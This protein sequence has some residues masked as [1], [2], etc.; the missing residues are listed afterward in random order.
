MTLLAAERIGKRFGGIIALGGVDFELRAGEIHALC[1]ENGAG[2]STLIKILSGIHTEYDGVLRLEGRE[3]R[4]RKVQ[5]SE[6]AGIAVIHQELALVEEMTVA[7]NV[8]L[9]AEPRRGR[10]IDWD[11]MVA[12]TRKVLAQFGLEIDVDAKVGT[13]GVAQRQLVEIAKALRKRSRILILDEPTAALA[14]HEAQ[15]LL[16]ILRDLRA[17]GI[18]CIYVSHRLDE[19]LSIADRLTVLRDG[20]SIITVDRATKAE[21]IRYMVGREI[22]ELY[23]QRSVKRGPAMLRVE[24][25]DVD[26]PTGLRGISFDAHAGEVLGIGGLMGAGRTELL[27]HICGAWGVRKRGRVLVGDALL[28][29][30][31]P[32][33]A[34]AAGVVLVS[35]DRKRYGL[36]LD[37]DIAFNLSL[38][39]IERFTSQGLV[40]EPL[41]YRRCDELRTALRIKARDLEVAARTLSGG[42]QQKV[43]LGKALLVEPKVVLLDEP[44]RGIDVGAKAEVY[45]L[46]GQ[47]T[48][49]GKTVVLVSSELPEL[50]GL[51]D[52]ILMLHEG[53]VAGVFDRKD[54]T[55]EKLLAAAM[56]Q[57]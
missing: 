38:S 25:L 22:T 41:L 36:V 52:R 26:G 57:A 46:L 47:L 35:E 11:R 9:G 17:R 7:E 43:V 27:M 14:E 45:E 56:G 30:K 3:V 31:T 48:A 18:A 28:E 34:M 1:G 55:P 20:K 54:A 5:D 6:A 2:K 4:F 44:T 16:G 19:V 23:P 39:V 51:S 40:D 24:N 49:D 53:A 50:L 8:F 21:L 37:Q 15:A 29:A 32:R 42:N 13:L 33:D 12:E 10:F